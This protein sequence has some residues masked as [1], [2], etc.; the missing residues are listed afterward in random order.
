MAGVLVVDDDASIRFTLEQLLQRDGHDVTAVATAK[1][2]LAELE[3]A[4]LVLTDLAM[5][6]MDGLEL[7]TEIR[8]RKPHAVVI[9][10]TAFGSERVAVNA[11]KA[12]AYDYV[13]KPF[14][15][16]DLR[17]RVRRALEK[18]DLRRENCKLH[19]ER[20][21]GRRFVFESVAMK[22][23]IDAVDRIAG[24]DVTVL[25]RGETGTGKEMVASLIH[26][27]SARRDRPLVRFNCAALPNELADAEL[28]GHA[29][30]AFTGAD[31]ARLG[32]FAKADKGTLIL[33]EVG[34]L[35]LAI[36]ATLLRAV[37]QGEVQRVGS[38]QVTQV[39]VRIVASTNRDLE[40]EVKAGRFREDL[41]YRLAVVDLV[42][43]PLRE[44]KE[45]IAPL[46]RE[47][48]RH[49]A[50]RFGLDDDDLPTAVVSRLE[51]QDWPGNVRQ[52]ENT[53]ARLAAMSRQS[54]ADADAS[55]VLDAP[56]SQAAPPSE[57]G[58]RAE[59]A[60]FERQL[61]VRALEAANG[62]MSQAA[63][64]LKIGRAT[65]FDKVQ[66]YELVTP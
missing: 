31:H 37:Q 48:A 62:N 13:A 57:A 19:A 24:R 39:D 60:S 30:G 14:D 2:A 11:I 22:R 45:D 49:Y 10:I 26:A 23:L 63:R 40:A 51:H 47:F 46:A 56:G 18:V 42:V 36:Q 66:K 12:G 17:Q 38:S 25:L 5:P 33:D 58:L 50:E 41:F 55:L 35:P 44:R 64:Y 1:E 3:D 27:G 7:L 4:D 15:N 61:I 20:A 52:L 8:K 29:K 9:M 53:V 54:F 28:F 6:E 32:F 59:V 43:P 65:L 34:E 21:L 16:D